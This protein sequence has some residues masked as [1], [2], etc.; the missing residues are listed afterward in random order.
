[1]ILSP[2]SSSQTT[3]GVLHLSVSYRPRACRA[4]PSSAGSWWLHWGNGKLMRTAAWSSG[5]DPSYTESSNR[6]VPGSWLVSGSWWP[7]GEMGHEMRGWARLGRPSNLHVGTRTGKVGRYSLPRISS[8]QR[9][10]SRYYSRVEDFLEWHKL[11]LCTW[12]GQRQ[13]P[14]ASA[15]CCLLPRWPEN[16]GHGQLVIRLFPNGYSGEGDIL[17]VYTQQAHQ[18]RQGIKKLLTGTQKIYSSYWDKCWWQTSPHLTVAFSAQSR[19]RKEKISVTL[20]GSFVSYFWSRKST[21]QSRPFKEKPPLICSL[22][23]PTW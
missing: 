12:W 4:P 14:R 6:R 11:Q 1:M 19:K 10:T 15:S 13:S 21:F 17:G 7:A 3:K 16:T 23:P 22:A 5:Q 9:N 8:C 18:H 20:P 2:F